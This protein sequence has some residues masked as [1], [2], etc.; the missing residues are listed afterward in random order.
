M[1]GD[2]YRAF[3]SPVTKQRYQ[4]ATLAAIVILFNFLY[5]EMTGLVEIRMHYEESIAGQVEELVGD[6]WYENGEEDS[7]RYLVLG[8]DEDGKFTDYELS[9]TMKYF[10]YASQVEIMTPVTVKELDK[11]L[12][13]YD[14]VILF[15]QGAVYGDEKA[16][17]TV[18]RKA[19]W[20]SEKLQ[21][22]LEGVLADSGSAIA[23]KS[24]M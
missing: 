6:N 7:R 1:Q 16:V 4:S 8:T 13:D 12:G 15:D 11:L 23:G 14:R 19:I 3:R 17:E 24:R 21:E 2:T 20:D 18:E 22:E 9:Y 10:L 5:S